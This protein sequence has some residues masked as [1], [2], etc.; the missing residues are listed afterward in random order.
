MWTAIGRIAGPLSPPLPVPR[1]GRRRRVSMRMPSTVLIA[2]TPSAP[3]SSHARATATTSGAF[4]VSFTMTGRSVSAFTARVSSAARLGSEPKII[5]SFT[6][7]HE[8]LSSYA[9][10]P[11][12][13][14]ISLTT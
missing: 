2:V 9:T 11:G 8:T 10:T 5:P 4:G 7:G 1:I 13:P 14:A 3:A 12:V 6:F